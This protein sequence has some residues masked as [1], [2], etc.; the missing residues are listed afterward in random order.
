MSRIPLAFLMPGEKG[1]VIEIIGGRGLV[2]RLYDMGLYPSA[3]VEVLSH[4]FGPMMVRVNGTTT[5][6]IGRGVGMKIIV[7]RV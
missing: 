7:R 1:V 2:K 6:A 3:V 5:I 4:G